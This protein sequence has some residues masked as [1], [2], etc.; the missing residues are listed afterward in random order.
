MTAPNNA[1]KVEWFYMSFYQEDSTR[2]LE[3]GRRLCGKKLETIAKYFKNIF[4]LQVADG[5]LTKKRGK[6]IKFCARR[7]LHHKMAK[8]YNDKIPNLANQR[9]RHDNHRYECSYSHHQNNNKKYICCNHNNHCSHNH[10]YKCDN[11]DRKSL[12]KCDSKA[13]KP[14]HLHGPKSQHTFKKFFKNPK[15][16]DKKSYSYDKK[17]A[18]KAHHT[19]KCHTSKDKESRTSMN[20]PAPSNSH[21]SPSE[22]EQHKEDKQYHLHFKKKLNVGSHVAHVPCK[23]KKR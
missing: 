15:N 1:L 2:Y 17:C 20:L 21:I 11:K 7:K 5:S 22:V 6:Q 13:F 23:K 19:D 14:F 3:S 8:R 4:N 12:T 9:Y 16:Q 18:Y 10:H